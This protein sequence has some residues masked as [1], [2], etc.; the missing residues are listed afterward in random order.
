MSMSVDELETKVSWNDE[1]I[2]FSFSFWKI[3]INFL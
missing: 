3:I 2:M 1:N